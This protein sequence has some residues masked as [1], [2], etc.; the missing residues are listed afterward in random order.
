MPPR[1]RLPFESDIYELEDLLER[2]ESGAN[3]PL[4][5]S[6]EIRRIRRELVGLK[7]KIYSNLTPWQTVLVSR[8]SDRPQTMDYV[9]HRARTNIFSAAPSPAQVAAASAAVDIIKSEPER[10]ELLWKNTRF[11]QEGF[12]SLGFE[13][14]PCWEPYSADPFSRCFERALDGAAGGDR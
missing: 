3:G 12:R 14:V 13:P 6:E 4:G 5:S 8:H 9:K 2:L 7:R 11:M 1:N 10:R